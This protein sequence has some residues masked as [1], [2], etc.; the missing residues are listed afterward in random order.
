METPHKL[1]VANEEETPEKPENSTEKYRKKIEPWLTAVFQSEHFNLLLGSGFPIAVGHAADAKATGMGLFDLGEFTTVINEHAT[2]SAK[3]TERGEANCEDQVRSALA[4]IAGLKIQKDAR[5][6]TLKTALDFALN[7]FLRSLLDTEAVIEAKICTND[8]KGLEARKQLTSFLL[9]FASRAAT[10]ERLHIFTTNYDRLIEYGCDMLGLRT[11]DRFVGT[12]SPVFRSSRIEVDM[13]YSP[14]GIRGEPRYLEGVV[15][16]TKLHGSLDWK[17]ENGKL[18]REALPF[19]PS[20][21]FPVY[22]KEVSDTVMIY[23]NPAKDVETLEYPYA[24]LFRDFSAAV[25]RPNSA[26]VTYGYGYG[27]DHINRIIADMLTIPSSHLVIIAFSDEGGRVA[28][29]CDRIGKPAQITLLIG[30]HFGA[31]Q[32]L[33]DYYLPKPAIDTIT[34]RAAELRERRGEKYEPREPATTI[35]PLAEEII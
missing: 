18:T 24:E 20:K 34:F 2:A 30:P 10:R 28:R 9:S 23:P 16:L 26:L 25:C 31:L 32:N 17:F 8:E 27:D 13:H 3:A 35:V 6:D 19:G 29:F 21:E 5:A 4:L 14:P 22:K 12:L 1:R 7:A 33:V 11:I 15:K